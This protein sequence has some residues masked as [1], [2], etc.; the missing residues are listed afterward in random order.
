MFDFNLSAKINSILERNA[1]TAMTDVRFFEQEISKWKRSKKR[2]DMIAGENYY[3]GEHDILNRVRTIIGK[4]GLLQEVENLPNNKIV[5]NQYGKMVNQKVDYLL[6]QP[7]TFSADNEKYVD[8]LKKIFNK[9]FHRTLKKL[10][11][12]SLN[13]GIAWLYVYYDDQGK[14]SFKTFEPYEILPFWKDSAHTI[15]DCAIRLYEV[16]GYEGEQ[17]VTIEKVELYEVNGIRRFELKNGTLVPD[18]EIPDST[19]IVIEDGNGNKSGYNWGKIPL[20]PFKYNNKEIPLINK[21][22]TLQDGLNTMLSDFEN[23]MQE[24]ARNT[25]L[26]IK[27]LDGTNLAEFRYNLAAYGAVKVRT[28]D[29]VAGEVD[30]LKIEINPENYR[31]ILE[32]FKNALIENAMGY[33]AKNDRMLGNPNQMNI[34][35]MYSD[36][37]LDANGMETEYQASFEELLWFINIYLAN[38]GRGNFED[39]DVT[40]IFNRNILINE[41]ETI[42]NCQK[43]VGILSNETIVSQHPWASDVEK[44]LQRIKEEKQMVMDEY[45]NAF[46]SAETEEL[47]DEE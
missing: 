47:G 21:V 4:D 33:D 27:N 26:V 45:E 44:E 39:E 13:G 7:L 28:V 38:I 9:R 46:N 42:D 18:V 43:S 5:D 10:G 8:D 19:Y 3:A 11:E 35:S 20:I 41:S 6:G 40:I 14:L 36:I 34:Q 16:E 2:K 37:D 1:K 15:L 24:D 25:I 22:K 12:D 17:E 32:V 30:A 29:G 23:N 31:T